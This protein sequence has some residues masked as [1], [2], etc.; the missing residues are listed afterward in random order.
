MNQSHWSRVRRLTAG[1]IF[2]FLA[3]LTQPAFAKTTHIRD[4]YP[5]LGRGIRPLG[6]GNAFLTMEGTDENALFYNPAAL[7]DFDKS[8]RYGFFSPA[9]TFNKRLYRTIRDVFDLATDIKNSAT[10]SGD[11]AAFQTFLNKHPGEHQ[12]VELRLP[13]VSM[14]RK[15]WGG[16]VLIDGRTTVSFR[17]VQSIPNF[18]I[19]SRN[20]AAFVLGKSI[21]LF[22]DDLSV[23]LLVK[24]LYRANL[25]KIVLVSDVSGG[26]ALGD[27]IG[28][29]QWGRAI[30]A[31]ADLGVRYRLPVFGLNPMVAVVYQD[32]AKTRFFESLPLSK[33]SVDDNPQSLNAG[34]GIHPTIGDFGL[35]VEASMDGINQRRDLLTKLHAGAEL[36][37]PW[38]GPT[39]LSLRAGTNQGYPAGGF[40]LDFKKLRIDGAFFGEETGEFARRGKS[41]KFAS[42]VALSF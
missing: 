26:L 10:A 24:G 30:G 5:N 2:L 42:E 21:G 7:Q 20:D 29:K 34:V 18:E 14:L 23:G 38:M 32:I 35:S 33:L 39:R 27:I 37:F 16:A 4:G 22:G 19:R 11:I 1:A 36:R 31:G 40:S 9:V 15:G 3:G 25:D 12:N 6:M 13:I 17:N 8:W 41:Y 28:Y